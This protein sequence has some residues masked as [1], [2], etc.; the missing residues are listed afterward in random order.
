MTNRRVVIV[1]GGSAGWVAAAYLNGALNRLRK[2]PRVEITLVESPDVPR[3]SVGEATIPSLNHVLEVAGIDETEFVKQ[4]DATYKQAIKY[5]NWCRNDGSDYYHPFTRGPFG[6]ID[7]TG[8][9]WARSDRSIPY[10]DTVSAQP[11]LCELGLV[12][13][14]PGPWTFGPPLHY[15]YHMNAL[16][17]ADFLTEH[18]TKRGVRH[19]RANMT[20]VIMRENGLIAAIETDS[21][22][23][24]DGD[25]FVDCTGFSAL[26]IDK[27]MGVGYYDASQFL[28]CDRAVVMPIPYDVTY[29]GELRPY[30]T[31]TALSAG[32]IWD[33]PLRSRRAIGYVHSSEFVSKDEAER[34]V[35]AYEGAHSEKLDTRFVNFQVG[36]RRRHWQGNCIAIG[37]SGGFI[38]PLESTGIYLAELGAVMLSEHFPYTEEHLA[39]LSF[40]Y[41]RILQNRY[42]EILDFINLHYC[43]TQRNDTAFWRE[44]QKPERIT[45]RIKA[46]LEF[47][48]AKRPSAADLE[49]QFFLGQTQ[50]LSEATGDQGLEDRRPPV[51]TAKLWSHYSYECI[52]YGMDFQTGY[53][54][55]DG[56]K[57]PAEIQPRVSARV[58]QLRQHLPRHEDYLRQTVGFETPPTGARPDGWA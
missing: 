9:N 34:E 57:P 2:G 55:A 51:D 19:V 12:P 27:Q 44:M 36:W 43:L 50:E 38:E 20:D 28:M 24:I 52:M 48:R 16:K 53:A 6:P 3:I 8:E 33:I 39:A 4:T 18:T 22:G 23:R 46:K 5:R 10:M 47:W 25:I 37:L 14:T 11:A 29:P 35:R 30:T 7:F 42:Y 40:R 56:A 13:K 1:G 58:A 41:N 45:D 17:F 49:D 26:L 15:A 21:A 32:W 54:E 31:A